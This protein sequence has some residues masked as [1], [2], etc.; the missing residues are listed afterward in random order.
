MSLLRIF[1]IR[2]SAKHS[3]DKRFQ[4]FFLIRESNATA[5]FLY[6]T[7]FFDS[8]I[9]VEYLIDDA[10]Q[11][12]MEECIKRA[13][14][15]KLKNP[16]NLIKTICLWSYIYIEHFYAGTSLEVDYSDIIVVMGY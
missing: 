4:Y 2:R 7:V 15:Y 3:K 16:V 12:M 8:G 10:D 6:L 1:P 9:I 5:L 14:V 13:R 11:S